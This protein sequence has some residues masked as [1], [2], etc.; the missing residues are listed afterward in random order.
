MALTKWLSEPSELANVRK[1]LYRRGSVIPDAHEN[2]SELLTAIQCGIC[3][4]VVTPDMGPR[5]CMNCKNVIFCGACLEKIKG[6]CGY[7]KAPNAEF[8]R[9][10]P[11]LM[12]ILRT[13]CVKCPNEGCSE[14]K[15]S[16]ILAK[17]V[18][19]ECE[20]RDKN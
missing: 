17:H 18:N 10:D 6:K 5:I 4:T 1:S 14:L 8:G 2:V 11:N 3:F 16:D 20:Y 15:Y 13:F 19:S 9:L 12:R 7:C